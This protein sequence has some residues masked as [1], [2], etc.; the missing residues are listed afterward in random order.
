MSLLSVDDLHAGYGRGN[1]LHGVSLDLEP[2]GVAVV[3]GANGAGKTTMMR[4][5]AGLIPH[6]G[7][8][9]FNGSPLGSKPETRRGRRRQPCPTGPWN[10]RSTVG[11]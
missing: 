7:T 3:L 4:A 1:V 5:L 2:G 8:I 10:S 9:T 11:T 6:Q